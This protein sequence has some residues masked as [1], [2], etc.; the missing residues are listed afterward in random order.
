VLEARGRSL[1]RQRAG[2]LSRRGRHPD[3]LRDGLILASRQVFV[4]VKASRESVSLPETAGRRS[5]DASP[6]AHWHVFTQ[7]DLRWQRESQFNQRAFR[8][9]SFAIEEH[10]AGAQVLGKARENTAIVANRHR[11]VQLEALG[12]AAFHAI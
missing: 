1:A 4:P 2:C 8:Q 10:A 7:S 11:E 3:Q 6:A 9:G 12:G 5:Q